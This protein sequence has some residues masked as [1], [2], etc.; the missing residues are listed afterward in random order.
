VKLE[1]ALTQY[2][3]ALTNLKLA[4]SEPSEIEILHILVARDAIE[5]ALSEKTQLSLES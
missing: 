1:L 5:E 2:T 4:K 3:D